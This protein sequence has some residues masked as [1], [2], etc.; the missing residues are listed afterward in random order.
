MTSISDT[1]VVN[2]PGGLVE[3]GYSQ[4]TNTVTVSSTLEGVSGTSIIPALTVVCDGSPILV[5][6]VAPRVITGSNTYVATGLIVDGVLQG[7]M[8]L[9]ASTNAGVL[10]SP[11]YGSFRLTPSAGPHTFAVTAFRGS[12]NGAVHND[13]NSRTYLRISKIIQASQLIVQTPNAPLVTSLPSNAID[14][15]EVRYLAD[16]TNGIIWNFRYRA[17]SPSSHKWEFI[18]GTPLRATGTG[19][20]SYASSSYTNTNTAALTT[21]LEGDY[22][23]EH[24]GFAQNQAS[25]L[26]AAIF[27]LFFAGV[28][29]TSTDASTVGTT[30]FDGASVYTSNVKTAVPA[31]TAVSV[32]YASSAGVNCSFVNIRLLATPIRVSA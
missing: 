8:T 5:E 17:G 21:P 9:T 20:G 1:N 3:L 25:G 2:A 10:E 15:Q 22:R 28:Q 30:T 7:R 31:S 24:G 32:R 14:G 29:D 19:L 18:G 23:F 27:R 11:A 4:I 16:N 12:S 26:T 13:T 6:F